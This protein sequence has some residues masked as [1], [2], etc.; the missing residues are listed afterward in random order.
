MIAAAA[1]AALSA[2]QQRSVCM[3]CLTR[4]SDLRRKAN[5]RAVSGR[6]FALRGQANDC[7]CCNGAMCLLAVKRP[8]IVLAELVLANAVLAAFFWKANGLGGPI[9]QQDLP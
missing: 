3:L 6:L 9:T 1:A 4:L 7:C 5:A 8:H 2:F